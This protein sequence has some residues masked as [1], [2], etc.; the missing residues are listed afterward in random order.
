MLLY[1]SSFTIDF[2]LNISINLTN[3]FSKLGEGLRLEKRKLRKNSN[4]DYFSI[5]DDYLITTSLNNNSRA[6]FYRSNTGYS[7][8][9]TYERGE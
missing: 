7:D 4:V 5:E 9:R 3:V 1:V 8:T 2:L 6:L